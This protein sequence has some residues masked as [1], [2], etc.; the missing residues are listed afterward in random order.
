[1]ILTNA[2]T[3]VQTF[4]LFISSCSL[5][6]VCRARRG[7]GNTLTQAQ[8]NA[9]YS[10]PPFELPARLAV[11]LNVVFSCLMY[12]AGNPVLLAVAAASMLFTLVVDKGGLLRVYG[13]PPHYA[14]SI[15][16]VAVKLLPIAG[17]VHMAVAV[18]TY[19]DETVMFS[20]NVFAKGDTSFLGSAIAGASNA[21]ASSASV[22]MRRSCW[23]AVT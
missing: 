23:R 13:K 10:P 5:M 7:A 11:M 3:H 21:I 2:Y 4:W 16:E 8:L 9:Q 22:R 20:P 6:N 15:V 18:W 12:S 17:L 1:M 19:S 14:G